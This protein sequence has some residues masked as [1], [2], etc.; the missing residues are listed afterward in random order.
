MP[1]TVAKAPK[2]LPDHA[3]EIYVAAFNA[4]YADTCK[5]DS[6]RDACASRIA[7]GAVKKKYKKDGDGS[8][9]PKSIDQELSELSL[10]ISKVSFDKKTGEMRWLAVASDTEEDL[11]QEYMSIDLFKDFIQRAEA[12]EEVPE[13]FQ[14]D[15]W[16]GG[17][18]YVSVSHYPDCNGTASAGICQSLYVD[19]NR[20]KA[21]G[22]FTDSDL[23]RACF[24]SVCESLYATPDIEKKVRISIGFLDWSHSHGDSNTFSRKNLDDFCMS[25]LMKSLGIEVGKKKYLKGQLIHLALTRE[26]ANPRT[27]ITDQMEVI[28]SMTTQKS[29]AASIVGDEL[30]E[31]IE[32]E[33]KKVI[34]KS[35]AFVVKTDA[36]G[37]PDATEQEDEE[38]ISAES[39]A[40]KAMAKDAKEKDEEE[41]PKK[42]DAKKEKKSI[43]EDG[44]LEKTLEVLTKME[45]SLNKPAPEPAP[46]HPLDESIVKIK[47]IFDTVSANKSL[48]KDEKLGAMQESFDALGQVLKA[49]F[50]EAVPE[51]VGASTTVAQPSLDVETLKTAF[52]E[53]VQPLAESVKLLLQYASAPNSELISRQDKTPVRRSLV[54]TPFTGELTQAPSVTQSAT[55][56][57][58]E[59][60]NRSVYLN[61]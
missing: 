22:I 39:V 40:E 38:E 37:E 48:S 45:A 34:G 42:K 33:A 43:A 11:T 3:K 56:K 1:I 32:E 52:Q 36:D 7:W 13:E 53:A 59:I 58:R 28:K 16:K 30:A 41:D 19:G 9:T 44:V 25:C 51:V 17:M 60:V 10:Y 50:G 2:T 15:Y 55:P 27:D 54:G 18:P 20:L 46:V 24:K 8:W 61:H 49:S 26:P 6:E 29:D 57:L 14:S 12:G 23:G 47:E 5:D 31:K 4:S 21:K 35:L